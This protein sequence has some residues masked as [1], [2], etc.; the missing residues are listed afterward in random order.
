MV[1]WD[2]W[3]KHVLPEVE[4]QELVF[5][6]L[7][8]NV[9]KDNESLNQL[10]FLI[11]HLVSNLGDLKN[12]NFAIAI[13]QAINKVMRVDLVY[14]NYL[15]EVPGEKI[16]TTPNNQKPTKQLQKPNYNQNV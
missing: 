5:S 1:N 16:E 13:L 7:V 14:T 9:F 10:E 3:I 11:T 15:Q 8:E 2:I 4:R 6:L 12:L